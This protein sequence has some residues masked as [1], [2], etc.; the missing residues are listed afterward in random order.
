MNKKQIVSFVVFII[1]LVVFISTVIWMLVIEHG[2]T[3]PSPLLSNVCFGK[4]PYW[5][6]GYQCAFP[7]QDQG[8]EA[9]GLISFS[10]FALWRFYSGKTKKIAL[11]QAL[12]LF[13]AVVALMIFVE[14]SLIW[15]LHLV[16]SGSLL[17]NVWWTEQVT[18][19]TC[20]IKAPNYS[21]SAN[22]CTFLNYGEAFIISAI[23]AIGGF[24]Y[25]DFSQ[26][27]DSKKIDDEIERKKKEAITS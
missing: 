11:A 3:G 5:Y 10:M 14:A 17:G 23:V 4:S 8:F 16:S 9:A 12:S 6:G 21:P 1:T 19:Q 26:P 18:S 7:N 20:F 2:F 25:E 24:F 13:G 27:F 22:N 15:D